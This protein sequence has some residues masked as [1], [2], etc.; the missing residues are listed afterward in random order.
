MVKF[1]EVYFHRIRKHTQMQMIILL[2]HQTQL[3]AS[4]KIWQ[5]N[6]TDDDVTNLLEL[7]PTLLLVAYFLMN[8]FVAHNNTS[9]ITPSTDR[10]HVSALPSPMHVFYT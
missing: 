7:V 3:N 9:L 4:G 6:D 2:R 10:E 5:M 8:K 1:Q